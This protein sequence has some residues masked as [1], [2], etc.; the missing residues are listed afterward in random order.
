MFETYFFILLA[1]GASTAVVA[2]ILLVF[3]LIKDL[4]NIY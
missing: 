1:I 4:F 3:I 2:L